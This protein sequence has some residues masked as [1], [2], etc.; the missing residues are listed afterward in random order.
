MTGVFFFFFFSPLF[1]FPRR[2]PI[3]RG[4][5]CRR[6]KHGVTSMNR[7]VA[8]IRK[9]YARPSFFSF[10][11]SLFFPCFAANRA[12]WLIDNLEDRCRVERSFSVKAPRFF[13]FFP[14]PLPLLPDRHHGVGV[15]HGLTTSIE[16]RRSQD[17]SRA[18]CAMPDIE[19]GAGRKGRSRL[20]PPPLSCPCLEE[21]AHSHGSSDPRYG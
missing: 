13:F 19:I 7:G 18:C 6:T 16:P 10:F 14:P 15:V 8:G 12:I 4:P 3:P 20:F 5:G 11:P 17:S 21:F 1:L 2:R 9:N